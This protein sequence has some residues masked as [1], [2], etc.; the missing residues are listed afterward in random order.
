MLSDFAVPT[1][2]YHYQAIVGE[3]YEERLRRIL[4]DQ[5]IYCPSA[6]Q[7]NDPWD[8]CPYFDIEDFHE[9]ARTRAGACWLADLSKLSANDR[10]VFVRKLQHDPV[11]RAQLISGITAEVT[12]NAKQRWRL[13]CLSPSPRINL[14][15]SHYAC[16]H[17]GICLEF[18]TSNPDFSK[19]KKV[20]YSRLLPRLRFRGDSETWPLDLLL[21]K[22]ED[23][24]YEQEFRLM[25]RPS[26][27]APKEMAEQ[28]SITEDNLMPLPSGALQSIIVG[29]RADIER[30]KKVVS[31]C[32]CRLP[33]RRAVQARDTYELEIQNL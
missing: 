20:S 1:L 27:F 15:W 21:T 2:L 14:M 24:A 4:L 33:I 13:Y 18:D 10:D 8:C 23:W 26:K 16:S 6:A 28:L 31:E 22:S 30:V 5:K 19:V 7:F 9:F 12:S 25:A 3:E 17:T 32:S 29:C 11:L